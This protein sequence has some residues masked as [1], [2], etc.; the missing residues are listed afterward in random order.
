MRSRMLI[1]IASA[2]F[3]VANASPLQAEERPLKVF[4]LAGTSNMLGGSAK[5]DNLPEELRGTVAEVLAYRG[6]EWVPLEAGKNLVG[7]EA[8]FGRVVAKHLGE[9]VGIFWTS[10]RYVASNSPGPGIMNLVKQSGEKGRP[11][12]I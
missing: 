4:V 10:V 1:M 6:G 12:E 8:T 3:G 2:L 5:V 9:P 7:N 11:V